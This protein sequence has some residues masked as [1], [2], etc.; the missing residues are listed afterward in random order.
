[1]GRRRRRSTRGGFVARLLGAMTPIFIGI[2]VLVMLVDGIFNDNQLLS[3]D[4]DQRSADQATRAAFA[5]AGGV[6]VGAELASALDN[7]R[8]RRNYLL[9]IDASG[10]MED[11]DNCAPSGQSKFS[12]V[13]PAVSSFLDSVSP[14]DYVGLIAFQRDEA[15]LLRPLGPP[16]KD[17]M[18]QAI[19]TITPG[20]RTP[21]GATLVLAKSVL[22]ARAAAQAGYGEYTIV[23]VTDG[24]ATDQ[25]MMDRMLSDI[26]LETPIIIQTIG[27]CLRRSHALNDPSRVI[28]RAADDGQ[29]LSQGLAAAVA[30]AS[31]FDAS[32]FEQ[33]N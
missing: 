13:A 12:V 14:D 20:G 17:E 26:T 21:I 1:M 19:S 18:L 8:V 27:F 2:F 6:G 32:D 31:D 5:W 22:E 24:A 15:S 4:P 10:S 33:L 30:E 25:E 29:A 16:R 7:N 23:L 28:Y 3:E 9:A 11:N